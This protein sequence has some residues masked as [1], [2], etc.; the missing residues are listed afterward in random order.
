VAGSSGLNVSY[1]APEA[2]LA[3][4]FFSRQKEIAACLE[5]FGRAEWLKLLHELG[6]GTFVGTSRRHF[7]QKRKA[8]QLLTAWVAALT[9]AGAEFIYDEELTSLQPGAPLQLG[10][11]SG[12]KVAARTALLALGGG[13]WLDAPPLWPEMLRKLGLELSELAPA[14][15]GFEIKA[16]AEFF[17]AADGQ[18][19]KGLILRT[20]RG[21]KQGE[22]LITKYGLEGTP[23]YT[24]GCSGRATLD[25]KPELSQER[26]E[27]RLA[28]G[29]GTV[30]QRVE[31]SA[32]LSKG[33]L[34]LAKQFAPPGAWDS[35]AAAA[36]TLKEFP[37]L[38]GAPRPLSEAI[39]S[40]GGLAWDELTADLE[41]K[42]IP[43]LFCA[44]EMVD[45]DAP[46][47]GFLIQACVATGHVAAGGIL[48]RL[49]G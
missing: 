44:G 14:N 5:R 15:T 36:A 22:L 10:F 46:T 23:I 34:L 28:S 32:R 38:L 25:L 11:H 17:A 21:E 35:N 40:R 27:E 7:L 18:P 29:R 12:R 2:E 19:I 43:G 13:S 30:W 1:E 8:S 16:P 45:W 41:L 3:G 24:V 20:A 31:N 26:L 37:L 47:G 4:F 6:E 48:K 49:K 39:S 33:A 9:A 42:K